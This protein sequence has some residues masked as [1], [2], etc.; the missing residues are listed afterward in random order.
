MVSSATS[1]SVNTHYITPKKLKYKYIQTWKRSLWTK[2]DSYGSDAARLL[3]WFNNSLGLRSGLTGKENRNYIIF[4]N[5]NNPLDCIMFWLWHHTPTF[6]WLSCGHK[7][8][9]NRTLKHLNGTSPSAA[10]NGEYFQVDVQSWGK[11]ITCALYCFHDLGG[12]K[13]DFRD[14]VKTIA[15]YD[16]WKSRVLNWRVLWK[17]LWELI[18]HWKACL[19]VNQTA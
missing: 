18:N 12:G 6:Y 3:D 15:I 5:F 4:L 19:P 2:S 11:F 16:T 13:E 14:D 9:E 7:L 1:K 17:D 10:V 8:A